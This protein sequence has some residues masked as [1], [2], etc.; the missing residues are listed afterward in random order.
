[1]LAVLGGFGVEG[2]AAVHAAR[3]LRSAAHGFAV[4]EAAG[5]FG[6]S[7]D[8]DASHERLIHMIIA[9]LRDGDAMHG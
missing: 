8:L 3:C 7:D 4:L 6:L 1:M 9:G 5:G 2:H